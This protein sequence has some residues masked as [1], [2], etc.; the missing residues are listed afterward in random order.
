MK[1]SL[2]ITALI[3]FTLTYAQT[4]QTTDST[5]TEQKTTH[6]KE[7]SRKKAEAKAARKKKNEQKAKQ[8]TAA[9]KRFEKSTELEHIGYDDRKDKSLLANPD[10]SKTW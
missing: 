10:S 2:L 5:T 3:L 1:Q 8:Q 4:S 6:K 7:K 9:V